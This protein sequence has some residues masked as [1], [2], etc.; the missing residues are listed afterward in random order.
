MW[1]PRLPRNEKVAARRCSG[2]G[3][4]ESDSDSKGCSG[5]S[6]AE[7]GGCGYEGRW[8]RLSSGDE[9]EEIKAA[10]KEGLAMV[11]ATRK[12][13]RGQQGPMRATAEVAAIEGRKGRGGRG[14]GRRQHRKCSVGRDGQRRWQGG[15][16]AVAGEMGN[17]DV[18]GQR[19]RRRAV[20]AAHEE[21]DNEQD[22][23]EVEYS[24]QAEK[25]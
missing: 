18:A 5:A 20:G 23:H 25:V 9:E 13:R 12:R 19:H 6:A 17:G 1:L 16:T 4:F 7:G 14:G 8:Q 21:R 3:T 15:E 10:A 2:R 11:E 22:E 24:S